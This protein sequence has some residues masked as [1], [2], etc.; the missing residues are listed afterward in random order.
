MKTIENKIMTITERAAGLVIA[1]DADYLAA[2]DWFK[3]IKDILKV[4]DAS[5]DPTIEAAHATHKAALAAKK[6]HA[7]PLLAAQ[8]VING[9]VAAYSQAKAAEA[10]RIEAERMAEARKKAEAEAAIRRKEEEDRR[11]SEA[12]VLQDAGQAEAAEILVS[13]P[14]VIET[15]PVVIEAAPGAPKIEGLHFRSVWKFR[16]LNK[17]SVPEEYK[18]VDEK[19]VGAVVRAMKQNTRIPGIEIYEEKITV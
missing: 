4:I 17:T 15:A 16:V 3:Q 13:A 2:G 5:F 6:K 18:V 9:K 8:R 12:Q 7:D 11:L 19:A 10:R 14:V 1:T